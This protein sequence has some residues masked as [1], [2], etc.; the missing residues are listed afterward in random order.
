M[1][2]IEFEHSKQVP[3]ILGLYYSFEA[4]TDQET[5]IFL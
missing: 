4:C 2:L 1:F 5:I 3:K